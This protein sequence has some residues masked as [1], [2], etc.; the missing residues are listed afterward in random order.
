MQT[1]EID[2][3][4]SIYRWSYKLFE[5]IKSTKGGTSLGEQERPV[6]SLRTANI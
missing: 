6:S 4:L 2:G 5:S 3:E 1:K